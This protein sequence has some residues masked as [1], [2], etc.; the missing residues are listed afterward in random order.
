MHLLQHPPVCVCLGIF[1]HPSPWCSRSA[2][3]ATCYYLGTH[4]APV[5][6]QN[7]A[8]LSSIFLSTIKENL[9]LL[10]FDCSSQTRP[11]ITHVEN[12]WSGVGVIKNEPLTK[13]DLCNMNKTIAARRIAS[14]VADNELNSFAIIEN[15]TWRLRT[16][17]P[18]INKSR[19]LSFFP[20]RLK[21][22]FKNIGEKLPS[23]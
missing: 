4:E 7:W 19:D 23:V 1:L 15:S 22:W 2:R 6:P 10:R 20:T 18:Q 14:V 21:I 13:L 3:I 16:N 17:K 11:Y 8:M 9:Y 12:Q 5:T